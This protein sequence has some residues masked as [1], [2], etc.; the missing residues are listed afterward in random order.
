MADI[1]KINPNGTEYNL[2]DAT[3]R[4]GLSSKAD[5]VSGATSDDFATL[6]SNGNLTDSGINSAIV[7]SGATSSNKLA[8]ANDIPTELNDL[9]DDVV[10]TSPQNAQVLT[11]NS[12]S[13]KWE[14]QAG[15]APIGGAVFKGSI[16]FTNIPTTGM[17]NGDW[18][19]IK[20]AFTTDSRFEEGA[21]IECT[22][23]TDIIWVS[24]DNK[25]NILTPSGVN[26]FNGRLG[27]VLPQ[28]GD[29]SKSDVGLGNVVNTGDS[30][31]PVSG[32][33]TKFTTGGAYTELNKK[34]DKVTS[35]TSGNFAGLDTNGNLTDSGSK[36]SDFSTVKTSE[37]ATSGGTTLSLVTTGEKYTWNNKVSKSSTAGLI[38]NDGTIDT[39]SYAT[40]ASAY[41]TSDT[42]ETTLADTDYFPFYDTSATA[43]RKTLWSNIKSVLKTYF[44]GIYSTF[45]GS[46]NDLTN[47][48]TIPSISNCYQST[49]TAET[50]FADDDKVPFYDTSATAKRNSTWA[51]IKSVLKT[52]FDTLYSTVKTRG[53]PTSGGTTLSLVN[54][55]DMYTWN[56]KANNSVV[57]TSANGLAPKVTDTS[58]Y[59]KGDG[60][61]AT[62]TNTWTAMVGATSSANGSV[63]Y[64]N[65][66]PPKD[67]YN[68]KYLRAD[69][70]W[71]VPPNNSVSQTAT[72]GNSTYEVLFSN[73]ANNTTETAGTRKDTGLTFNPSTD[74]LA[75]GKK[76]TG[77]LENYI[78]TGTG[79][80]GEDKGSSVSPRYYATT[81]TFNYGQNPVDGDM[82]MIKVPCA[83]TVAV[84]L[85]TDNGTTYYPVGIQSNS[86]SLATRLSTQYATGTYLH[87]VYESS[88]QISTYERGGVDAV[89]TLTGM[90]RV[91]NY[92]DSNT[93]YSAMAQS[94]ADTGTATTGRTI[95]AKVL[96]DT[97]FK[98][99]PTAYCTTAAGTAAKTATC[100]GYAL[101]SNS[102]I[103]VIIVNSNTSK[104]AL[105]LAINGKT[106][107]PIYING[108]ASS[109]SNYTLNAGSYLV[110]YNGTNYYFRNDG[111]ITSGGVVNTS[112]SILTPTWAGTAIQLAEGDTTVTFT[113]LNT[114]YAYEMYSETADGTPIY[115]TN[116]AVSGTSITYTILP[117]TSAQTGSGGTGCHVKLKCLY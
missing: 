20:D 26:S 58:K 24:D 13:G 41:S 52:Y 74:T 46:Y 99:A 27:A 68:T 6:D 71:V 8:T 10:I 61:W 34:A 87:L 15:S 22:A 96:N 32:G 115:V 50:T 82:I 18:Y 3:A 85:S 63:G 86:S 16:L 17:A 78:V 54:T 116:Y 38:K 73:S 95:T 7:P 14:N 102:Y 29:Y 117:I 55:G 42:A 107:K 110:Y 75:V 19:D 77:K 89:T 47:K 90:W 49:D 25:W 93:T 80:Q 28:S 48:P 36:A 83:G 76:I 70:T 84:W 37:S 9:S 53:T 72:S 21:G 57:S 104:S 23:G 62:P 79:V 106:A 100:G 56:N 60:T 40:A 1:S 81:W 67:G 44:D 65:T 108:S 59:L 45:S 103:Q 112:N 11:Y 105:T 33:T 111:K 88:S 43:K 94:E 4:Q 109:A 30:A 5:K 51:N 35:A 114:N 91:M 2:K 101:L 113:G 64:V 66:V 31:T 12:T 92:Y 39:T 98:K 69:A 97:I